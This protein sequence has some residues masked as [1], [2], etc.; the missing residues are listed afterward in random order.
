M[1]RLHQI[2]TEHERK[3]TALALPQSSPPHRRHPERSEGFPYFAFVLACMI[4][5]IAACNKTAS[6]VVTTTPPSAS[7][8]NQSNQASATPLSVAEALKEADTIGSNPIRVKGH[9]WW[10]KEGSMIY[11]GHYEPVLL[12]G[13]SKAFDAKH[14]YAATFGPDSG[15]KSDIATVIGHFEHEQNGKLYLMIDDI[16]FES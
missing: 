9:F 3:G 8:V 13:Y 4:L 11:D 1:E 6:N 14:S 16:A 10:G 15:H 2:T 5:P 12:V 7:T